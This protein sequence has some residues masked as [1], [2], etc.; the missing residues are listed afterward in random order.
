MATGQNPFG[1]S[2]GKEELVMR[3]GDSKTVA[4]MVDGKG[5]TT[6]GAGYVGQMIKELDNEGRKQTQHLEYDDWTDEETQDMIGNVSYDI[7]RHL[8]PETGQEDIE[9]VAESLYKQFAQN[10]NGRLS[11][12][13]NYLKNGFEADQEAYGL[14]REDMERQVIGAIRTA[15][16]DRQDT[17][18]Y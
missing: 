2:L 16:K 14:S 6:L 5:I 4:D 7:G 10:D 9:D 12:V 3:V 15:F 13:G 11:F 17:E 1:E 18:E 8:A